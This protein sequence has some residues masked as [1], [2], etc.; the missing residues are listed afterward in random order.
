MCNKMDAKDLCVITLLAGS[1]YTL[2]T[3]LTL[4]EVKGNILEGAMY[5][6]YGVGL[7]SV[8][9]IFMNT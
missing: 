7:V 2:N 5:F 4:S 9:H 3:G 8:L 6:S 1:I